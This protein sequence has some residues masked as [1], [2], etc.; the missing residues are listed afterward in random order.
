MTTMIE[1]FCRDPI[2][3]R[4]GRP[5]GADQGNRMR[6]LDWPLP[7]VLAGSLRTTL[8]KSANRTFSPDVARELLQVEIAGPLPRAAGQLYLPA[9]EDC[10]VHHD[11]GPLRAAPQ[12]LDA[13]GCDW[14]A[15]SLLPVRLTEEQAAEDFKPAAAPAWWPVDR[16][17]AWL[18]GES[19]AFG[20]QFL[21][22]AR[23]EERTHAVIDPQSG[24]ARE[25]KLFTTSALVLRSLP[26]CQSK[27][28][29]ETASSAVKRDMPI[30]LMARVRANGWCGETAA[31][32]NNLHPFGG[33]RRL[34]HW[35]AADAGAWECPE[36]VRTA[37]D[38]AKQVRMALAT[39]AIFSG[40]WKPGWLQEEN[41][42]LVGMPPGVNVTLQLIGASIR[43]WQAV[44]GWSLAEV[45]QQK[46]GPKPVKRMVPAGGVYFL[47]VVEGNARELAGLWLES[48]SDGEQD[49]R[50]GFGLAAWGVW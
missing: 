18:A 17:A 38:S 50:D 4:D 13:G 35:K 6:S 36:K 21:L 46:R 37:L 49:R 24:A 30:A 28:S 29:I 14:P 7:S 32:L 22:A 42:V 19:V 10:V 9:P 31:R 1:I 40:G 48:I 26:R 11:K 20:A 16:Y 44:S 5:F 47:E 15:G 43:R 33:E 45:G 12:P 23:K 2:V 8:G 3:A 25:P 41:G 27:G 34:A 39:P